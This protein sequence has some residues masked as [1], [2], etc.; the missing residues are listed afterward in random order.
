MYDEHVH[1]GRFNDGKYYEPKQVARDMQTL[2]IDRWI[3][4]STS[5]GNLFPFDEDGV[6]REVEEVLEIA[7]GH[8]FPFLWVLPEMF[9]VSHNLERYFFTR[10]YGLK[11]H[12]LI[13][14][15]PPDGEAI[16]SLFS[17]AK[18]RSLPIM[19]HTGE[20]PLCD[21]GIYMNICK[22]YPEVRVVLAHGRPL[23]HA[24]AVLKACPNVYVDIAFMP[25]KDIRTL[26]SKGLW[27]RVLYGTDYPITQYF[28]RTPRLAYYRR[29]IKSVEHA[30]GAKAFKELSSQSRFDSFLFGKPSTA[31][32]S[33]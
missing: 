4:S 23:E 30:V 10:Y 6:K 8:A 17:T 22:K 19:F 9:S 14:D 20:H 3:F 16:T 32:G 5:T 2:G 33:E 12:G 28:Y 13:S 21:A 29:R 27:N 15:W 31:A 11:V 24:I 26:Q 1:V 25:T 7:A 18:E